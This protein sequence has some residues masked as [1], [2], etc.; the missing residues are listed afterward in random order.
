VNAARRKY[1]IRANAAAAIV[2]FAG[3][4][5]CNRELAPRFRTLNKSDVSRVLNGAGG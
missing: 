4:P 1:R 3:R 5:A 2:E